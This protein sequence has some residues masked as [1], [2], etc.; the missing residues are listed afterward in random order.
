MIFIC[1]NAG[2]RPIV[3]TVY[4]FDPAFVGANFDPAIDAMNKGIRQLNVPVIDLEQVFLNQSGYTS[5]GVHPIAA[6]YDLMRDAYT[7]VLTGLTD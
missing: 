2:V 6:G 1:K 4:H 7:A 3:A 5:V